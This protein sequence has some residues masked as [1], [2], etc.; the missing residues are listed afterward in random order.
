[1]GVWQVNRGVVIEA[2]HKGNKLVS[3]TKTWLQ[4]SHNKVVIIMWL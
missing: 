4:S 1:M 2:K 3:E